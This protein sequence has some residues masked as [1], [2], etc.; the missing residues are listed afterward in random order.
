MRRLIAAWVLAL[1]LPCWAAAEDGFR[2]VVHPSNPADSIPK[3]QLSQLFLKKATRWPSGQSVQP[4]EAADDGVLEKFCQKVH[5]KSLNAVKAYWNQL[6]FAGR[7][8]PPL[9]KRSDE[10]VIAYVHANPGA[11]GI[12]SPGAAT[13]GVKV[14]STK[15]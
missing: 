3:A 9:E 14:V 7:E 8:V 10:E 5:G 13:A 15:D 2:V 11:V 6:I 4:V 1:A 12:V